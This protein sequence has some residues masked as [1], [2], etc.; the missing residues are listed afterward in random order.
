[1]AE[2][3]LS[4]NT[5]ALGKVLLQAQ[6]AQYDRD[7]ERRDLE[8]QA[9]LDPMNVDVQ[10]RIEELIQQENIESN[11]QD[12]LEYM[13]ESFGSVVMLYI[14]VKINGMPLR[15]FVDSGAQMT[16]M[17]QECAERCGIFRMMD[18]RFQG[19]AVGV[20]Q[21]KILGRVHMY[22]MEIAGAHLPTS[23][24][25]LENQ[26]MDLLLGLDMLRRHQCIIDLKRNV[27]HVGSTGA[28]T[29]FLSE[30]DIPKRERLSAIPTEDTPGAVCSKQGVQAGCLGHVS[31]SVSRSPRHR[32]LLSLRL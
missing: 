25:I 23:F 7:K 20:G 10:R 4:N 5:D 22:Q 11:R 31:S 6:Q 21:Q 32:P 1:M 8:R 13:P 27:L 15:A 3:I 16:I 2:M 28:E 19:M 12:A 17:S 30:A 14:H 29:P 9:S 24:S 26:P 18:T